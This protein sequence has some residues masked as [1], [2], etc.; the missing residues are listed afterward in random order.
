MGFLADAPKFS[1]DAAHLTYADID[2]A[3]IW[4][5]NSGAAPPYEALLGYITA[6]FQQ[7]EPPIEA[8]RSSCGILM[9]GRDK[10]HARAAAR[11]P[12]YYDTILV[13]GNWM[14]LGT[15]TAEQKCCA[16]ITRVLNKEGMVLNVEQA[17]DQVQAILR[18]AGYDHLLGRDEHAAG[19]AEMVG[20][21]ATQLT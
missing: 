6:P 9:G 14:K 21:R 16:L 18:T 19:A 4:L 5:Y 20:Y 11:K 1:T 17:A 2:K 3:L 10:H 12:I 8:E 7:L 13:D 15:K